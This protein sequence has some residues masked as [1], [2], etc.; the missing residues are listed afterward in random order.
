MLL[1]LILSTQAYQIKLVCRSVVVTCL[2]IHAV[3][4]IIRVS[5]Y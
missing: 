4:V 3:Q 5:G 2:G 1:C